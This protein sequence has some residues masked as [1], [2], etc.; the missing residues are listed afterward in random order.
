MI[1]AKLYESR[2]EDVLGQT[3]SEDKTVMRLLNSARI[4]DE[5]A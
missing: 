2:G 1:A 5:F 4:W 3:V